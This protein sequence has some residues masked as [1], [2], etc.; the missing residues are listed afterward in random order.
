VTFANVIEEGDVEV[1]FK[2]LA[3]PKDVAQ[4]VRA[5][6]VTLPTKGIRE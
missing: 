6:F 5:G 3:H 4:T 1:A 2:A